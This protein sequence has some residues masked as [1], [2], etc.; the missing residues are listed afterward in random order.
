M[1][2][3]RVLPLSLRRYHEAEGRS[4]P[5]SILSTVSLEVRPFCH[6]RI[7]PITPLGSV[8]T[9][10]QLD[11]AGRLW[12]YKTETHTRTA[13]PVGAL[14]D[15]TSTKTLCLGDLPAAAKRRCLAPFLVGLSGEG[16]AR[17]SERKRSATFTP[18]EGRRDFFRSGWLSD[19]TSPSDWIGWF[20]IKGFVLVYGSQ[21]FMIC[22]AQ[23]R[24]RWAEALIC[25][26]LDQCAR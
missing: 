21:A 13:L 23:T 5:R 24:M 4:L 12:P 20:S 8:S 1:P 7:G 18:T 22:S 26:G 3:P 6:V 17:T 9:T 25:S 15:T 10:G 16:K 14:R 19:K 2:Y 11:K